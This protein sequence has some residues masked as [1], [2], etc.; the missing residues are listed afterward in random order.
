VSPA[1]V[2]ALWLSERASSQARLEAWR[3][4]VAARAAGHAVRILD[5][6]TSPTDEPTDA[7]SDPEGRLLDALAREGTSPERVAANEVL[8]ALRGARSVIALLDAG[9]SPAAPLVTIDEALVAQPAD[10]LLAHLRAAS[11][12]LRA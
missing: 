2:L 4:L 8:A 3:T 1:T 10:A 5:L 7:P 6:R 9:R 11:C 12:V